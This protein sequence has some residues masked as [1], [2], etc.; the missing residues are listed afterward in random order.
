MPL[1][2]KDSLSLAAAANTNLTISGS[3]GGTGYVAIPGPGTVTLSYSNNTY[4]GGTAI[5]GGTLSLGPMG[6]SL[7]INGTTNSSDVGLGTV[8]VNAGGTLIGD[9]GALGIGWVPWRPR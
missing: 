3:M 2:F 8:T 5:S 1:V 4:P 9:T 7:N 6:S